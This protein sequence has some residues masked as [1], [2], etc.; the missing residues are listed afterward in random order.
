MFEQKIIRRME[1]D[2]I[3]FPDASIDLITCNQVMEH[4]PDLDVVLKEIQRVLKP[5]GQMLS[6]FPDRSVVREGHCGIPFL[7]WFPKRSRARVYYTAA[8]RGLGLGYH[9]GG[10]SVMQWSRDICVWLDNWTYYRSLPEIRQ[11]YLSVFESLQFVETE[12]LH[13]RLGEQH[14]IIKFAPNFLKTLIVR[15]LGFLAFVATK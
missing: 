10:K 12:W 1:G 6:L 7:H 8:L 5:G 9:K 13:K 14:P 11:K 15:K 4:V 2:S 3:P